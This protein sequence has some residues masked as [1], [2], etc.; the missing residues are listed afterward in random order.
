[1]KTFLLKAVSA[2][3]VGLS[4]QAYAQNLSES[5]EGTF[6][7]TG[8]NIHN[9]GSTTNWQQTT[10]TPQNGLQSARLNSGNHDD[11]LIAPKVSV[12]S[13]T[14]SMYF[15]ARKSSSTTNL[16]VDVLGS[17]TGSDSASFV[18]VIDTAFNLTSSWTKYAFGLGDFIGQEVYF[19]LHS[20]TY[21]GTTFYVDNFQGPSVFI[22]PCPSISTVD[23]T[24]ETSEGATFT[25][26]SML[27]A[28]AYSYNVFE[29]GEGPN[30]VSL[31][32]G[33]TLDTFVTVTGVP[34]ISNLEIWF[35]YSCGISG[36]SEVT[37]PFSFETLCGTETEAYS[38]NFDD[39]VPQCWTEAKGQITSNTV[40]TSITSSLWTQDGFANNGTSGAARV[41]VAYT[42]RRDWLFSP[43][44]N[45]DSIAN[46][47]VSF[48]AA[49]TD[50]GNSDAPDNDNLGDDDKVHIVISTDN[51]AT[52]SSDNILMT[53]DTANTPSHVGEFYTIDLSAYTGQVKVG[54]YAESTISNDNTDF[55]ID[56]FS[57]GAAT[58]C[59]P[60]SDVIVDSVTSEDIYLSWTN[61]NTATD[62]VVEYGE[63]GFSIGTGTVMNATGSNAV[64]S[65]LSAVTEY[66]FYVR[67]LC[68]TTDS[69]VWSIVSSATTDC[70][71]LVSTY[72]QDFASYLPECWEEAKGQIADTTIFTSA[73]SS[74]TND[75]FGNVGS[76]G[77]ARV[78]LF[79]TGQYEWLMS[80]S[81]DLDSIP[82]SEISFFA[83]LTA[84]GN[85]GTPINGNLGHDD[86]V[87]VVIST[88]NGLTWSS[89]NILM[90]FDTANIPSN[91]GSFYN[92]SLAAYT[93]IVRIGFYAQSTVYNNDNDFFIDDFKWSEE[94]NCVPVADIS[95]DSVFANDAYLS[96]SNANT[97]N[98]FI[99]EYGEDGF[100]LGTG[101]QL[102]STDT[103]VTI[104]N[105]DPL[106][107]Y[108]FYI[109]SI[110]SVGDSSIWSFA[111]SFTTE[112]AYITETYIEDFSTYLPSCWQE[113]AG[114]IGSPTSF[115]ST[116]TSTWIEDGFLNNGSSGAARINIYGS[117]ADEWLIT[118]TLDLDSIPNSQISFYA[119]LTDYFNSNA[120][121]SGNFGVDDKVHVVI[122][123]DNGDTWSDNNILMTFDTANVPPHTGGYYSVDLSAYSGLIK[124]GFYAESTVSNEDNDFFI[125]SFSWGE[126]PTCLPIVSTTIDSLFESDAYLSIINP[127]GVD[128]FII[129]YGEAGFELG[130]GTVLTSL[131]TNIHISGLTPITEYEVYI[132]NVCAAGDTSITILPF[133]FTTECPIYVSTYTQDFTT[134]IPTCWEEADGIIL[135]T[136]IFTSNSSDWTS[137]GFLNN[138]SSGAARVNVSGTSKK[139]WLITS[140]LNLDMISNSH[141]EFYAGVTDA[142]STNA[143]DNGTLGPDDKIHVVISV[144]NG[145][146]WSDDNILLTFDEN[147]TPSH[148]GQYYSIP[149]SAYSG[150]VKIGFYAESTVS[151]ESN[152]FSIDNFKW[153]AMPPCG[154]V[155]IVNVDTTYSTVAVINWENVNPPGVTYLVEYGSPGFTLGT[156]TQVVSTDTFYAITG[157]DPITTYQAYVTTLCTPVDTASWSTGVYFT[158]ECQVATAYFTED[159][160]TYLPQCWEEAEGTIGTPTTFTS[161]TSSSWR[162]DG[163]LNSGTTGASRINISGSFTNEWLISSTIDLDAQ[164]YS[165]I[166]FDAGLTDAGNSNAPDNGSFGIDDRVVVVISLDNGITWSEANT[167]ITFDQSN[168]PSYLG[169]H[170]SI[171]LI[172]YTG[173]VKI[174]FYAESTTFNESNDFFVDNFQ[175]SEAPSCL[176]TNVYG[177]DDVS[178][179][180]AVVT[181]VNANGV[182][183]YVIEYGV[184]GFTLGTG[185]TVTVTDTFTT[186]TGLTPNSSYQIYV[187]AICSST[188]TAAF[189]LGFTFSTECSLLDDGSIEEFGTYLP[190]CW[191][192]ARGIIA[193]NTVFTSTSSAWGQDGYL[194]VGSTGSARANIYGT[195]HREWLISPSINLNSSPKQI[196]FDAG[197][198]DYIGS[199][200]D[201]FGDDDKFQIVISTDNGITWSD[202]NVLMT[203][204]T[205]N[206][207]P[208]A[209]DHYVIS[210]Q[211][212]TGEVKIGFYSESTQSNNDFNVYV[213]NFEVKDKDITSNDL[214]AFDAGVN[215]VSCVGSTNNLLITIQSDGL[216][217]ADSFYLDVNI[218]GNTMYNNGNVHYVQHLGLG[219]YTPINITNVGAFAV[220]TYTGQA[221][222][223][224][225]YDTDAT[226][227]TLLF[228]FEIVD[229]PVVNAGNDVTICNGDDF[230]LD[231]S[232]AVSYTWTGGLSNGAIVSPTTTT[233]YIVTGVNAAGCEALDTI[234]VNVISGLNP[235]IISFGGYIAS[236]SNFTTYTWTFNGVVIGN[237][238]QVE[239]E[240]NGVYTLT[241]TNATGCS[242]SVDYTVSGIGLADINSVNISVYPNPTS[243][244][245]NISSEKTITNLSIVDTRGREVFSRHI[246]NVSQINVS[247][248]SK[249]YYI[250]RGEVDGQLFQSKFTKQ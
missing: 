238:S 236:A 62:I 217:P 149:L 208:N 8:W 231:A 193:Q 31:A 59:L 130:T 15:W 78:N 139:E 42:S 90:T 37:G 73:S 9:Y 53:F 16:T 67:S 21:N 55:F 201:D 230:Q 222:V 175:W 169:Q 60:V 224:N 14:D 233:D 227:D 127:N 207:L 202:T 237:T 197:L 88:D 82:N 171:P 187:K 118:P 63:S 50:N 232:G 142:F 103:F 126:V 113:A 145:V 239:P 195:S 206:V 2:L 146:T 148:L 162:E 144:D 151:N 138:G 68:S 180:A 136:T 153:E 150:V 104:S 45:L 13:V 247:N 176:P 24:D 115:S 177:L 244:I 158:T 214:I 108:E 52:W 18:H 114:S 7:P 95:I 98:N 218:T 190:E 132:Q 155:S 210:L 143:P 79:T 46:S 61:H 205:A 147:N 38:Q 152:D 83:A 203:F 154:Q 234:T 43:T 167:L 123:T 48:F 129:E 102:T 163:Y 74:W 215:A 12:S 27:N 179:T 245:L 191:T 200:T 119:G 17:T 140:S 137:D 213:D 5:F 72:D 121:E 47:E 120:P 250:I 111:N 80:P 161:T 94:S 241:V 107:E 170:Y 181:W 110:C 57:W 178:D 64:I 185:T 166:E 97:L 134:Y 182:S 89:D 196:E 116:T 249:G 228:S 194:N 220:G 39:Y 229:Y 36:T 100:T 122:S 29:A 93:G 133:S 44:L 164:T 22:N 246:L 125:D 58:T 240:D 87:S 128:N 91:T 248:L 159:F 41:N 10:T 3:V 11:W 106:T 216:N 198:T 56:N 141:I 174:G 34:S 124:I 221:I 19:G 211:G 212:Y 85:T 189:N 65:G 33:S 66:D 173:Q 188:D 157:L 86:T 70:E 156:G 160:S 243:E 71:V 219:S 96:W 225:I 35:N 105:L 199:G 75:G 32:S 26:N 109:R 20:H 1:M 49:L 6:P 51:G 168:T 101:T 186:L 204:D 235:M 209:G 84:Y 226:N 54:F 4:A 131:D 99:I 183:D 30:G 25:W 23:I 172:G 117:F 76:S 192:E 92:I 77:A 165:Q 69:S 242:A 112:C 40:F 135:D 81:L 223:N 184:P 28:D